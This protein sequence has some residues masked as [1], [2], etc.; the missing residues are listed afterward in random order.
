MPSTSC[1]HFSAISGQRLISR[2]RNKSKRSILRR[3]NVE[4][5]CFHSKSPTK[6]PIPNVVYV[7]WL[8]NPELGFLNY[9]TIRSALISLQPDQINL[10]Y[11]DLNERNGWF[12]KRH[13]NIT[14]V[15]HDLETEYGQQVQDDWQTSHIADLLRLDIITQEGGIYLDMEVIALQ[16][17]DSLLDCKKDLILGHEGGDRHGLCNAIII[18]RPG[19]SFV[20]RWRESYS[21]FATGEWNYHSVIL[22]KELSSLHNDKNLYGLAFSLLLA[23]MDTEA[24]SIHA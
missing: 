5:E 24:Y 6:T 10:H 3:R 2:E 4:K 12:M 22:P 7:I 16:P 23:H 18:A 9:L 17:F 14:L 13:D 1:S 19:S 11:T 8:K 15:Q 21:S 20:K